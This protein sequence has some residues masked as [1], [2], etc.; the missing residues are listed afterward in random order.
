MKKFTFQKHLFLFSLGIITLTGYSQE[1]GST[2]TMVKEGKIIPCTIAEYDKYLSKKKAKRQTEAEFELW[3]E[4]KI[5]ENKL[6]KDGGT[7][8]AIVTI[9]VIFHIIHNGDP[10]GTDENIPD[11]QILAQLQVLNEDFRRMAGTPGYNDNPVGADI[12]VE[13]CLAQRDPEGDATS[14][15]ERINAGY[16]SFTGFEQTEVLK[17]VTIWDSN[18]YLNI[19]VCKLSGDMESTG[20]YSF[21]PDGST[22][23]GLEGV[24]SSA[25]ND[26]VLLNYLA[27]G[28]SD[29]YPDGDYFPYNDKGRS[30]THELGHFFGLRHVSGDP[31]TPCTGTDYCDDTPVIAAYNTGCT[32]GDSCPEQPGTDMIE[33]HMDYTDDV[34]KNIFTVDQKTRIRTVIENAPRRIA[35]ANSNACIYPLEIDGSLKIDDVNLNCSTT[36]N[37]TVILVNKGLN[38]LTSATIS[39]SIDNSTPVAYAWTGSLTTAASVIVTLPALTATEGNHTFNAELLLPN[40]SADLYSGNNKRALTFTKNTAVSYPTNQVVF[41]LQRDKYGSETTWALKNSEGT[42]LYSGG[43]YSDVTTLPALITQTFNLTDN[44]CYIFTINDSFGD[45]ICC[46]EGNGYYNLKTPTGQV[47]A[48]GSSFEYKDQKAFGINLLVG[49]EENIFSGIEIYPNPVKDVLYINLPN[50]TFMPDG[51]EISNV[52]GQLISQKAIQSQDGLRA[53]TSA[54]SKGVYFIKIKKENQVKT[55]KFIKE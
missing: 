42:T 43:P 13:F 1:K 55:L 7:T 48:Q 22:L 6:Q 24:E 45:G 12:E 51:Y 54:L 30:A 23:E 14:G 21:F 16:E 25:E 34:C 38:T 40:G 44:Q 37:P 50:L 3:M 8:N 47:I 9:P 41:Q 36:F 49:V 19:W 35:L 33:N 26:G 2:T 31:D 29:I 15:I 39:Y 20:G 10:I 28:S 4:K 53:D 11:A 18:L 5:K 52:T 32:P 17:Q 27:V 46:T